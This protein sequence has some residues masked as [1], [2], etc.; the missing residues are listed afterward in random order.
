M[1]KLGDMRSNLVQLK[2]IT[3]GATFCNFLKKMA[4]L[5]PL[6]HISRVFRVMWKK[7]IFSN[8]KHSCKSGR[9]FQVG[10]GPKVDKN[11]GIN[12]GLRRG[13]CLRC[14]KM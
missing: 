10:F 1:S 2:R 5:M 4:I 7:Q 6:D 9:A 8:Y 3:D 14:T 11:F 12:S 13:F